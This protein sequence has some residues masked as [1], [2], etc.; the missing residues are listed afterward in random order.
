MSKF[1]VPTTVR[2]KGL[3]WTVR[4]TQPAVAIYQLEA[5]GVNVNGTVLPPVFGKTILQEKIASGE[6]TRIRARESDTQSRPESRKSATDILD[7]IQDMIGD[8]VEGEY[9]DGTH[10]VVGLAIENLKA[11]RDLLT[12]MN[13]KSE[14]GK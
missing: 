11:L 6:M 12:A 1:I 13:V 7:T 14:E 3:Y 10:P 8:L 5:I 4:Q 9:D 2:W